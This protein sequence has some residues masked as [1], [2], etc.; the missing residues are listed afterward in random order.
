MALSASIYIYVYIHIYIYILRLIYLQRIADKC[1]HTPTHNSEINNRLCVQSKCDTH[2]LTHNNNQQQHIEQIPY[3]SPIGSPVW[4]TS[5]IN[6]L[7]VTNYNWTYIS[8]PCYYAVPVGHEL[9][10]RVGQSHTLCRTS[11]THTHTHTH[12]YIYIYTR[13]YVRHSC[14]FQ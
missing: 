11:H 2:C 10:Q 13:T 8:W 12:T 1:Q 4:E 6:M 9:W 5:H 14:I 3:V 7:T